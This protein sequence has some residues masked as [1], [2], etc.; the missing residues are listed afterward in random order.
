MLG[1]SICGGYEP[2]PEL[3]RIVR[4]ALDIETSLVIVNENSAHLSRSTIKK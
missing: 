3:Q 2:G 1:A 4:L